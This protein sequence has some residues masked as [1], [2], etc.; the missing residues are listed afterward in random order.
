[1]NMKMIL[2]GAMALCGTSSF[3][4][5]TMDTL[6]GPY[7]I[8]MQP[9][10]GCEKGAE[11]V[12]QRLVD[13]YLPIAEEY[14]G[15]PFGGEAPSR[16]F[17]IRVKRN[18]GSDHDHYTGPSWGSCSDG[19]DQFTIGLAN[20]SDKWEMDLPLVASKVLTVCQESGSA[21]LRVYANRLVRGRV[22]GF[23]PIPRLR[24]EIKKGL[25]SEDDSSWCCKIAPMWAV[26]EE[27]R[28]N[29]PTF[30]FDYCNLKN[31][32]YAKG[33][34]PQRLSLTQVEALLGEVTGENV[35]ELFEEYGVIKK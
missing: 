6:T 18:D 21:A 11:Y 27:L 26:F 30:L 8:Q 17:T 35:R 19:I 34:L 10:S 3:G 22:E 9:D 16:V 24:A 13:V 29:H 32:L 14:Y 1:M 12:L 15:N 7:G 23:D 25:E 4:S 20:G 5:G 2:I 28:E 31:A 33:K